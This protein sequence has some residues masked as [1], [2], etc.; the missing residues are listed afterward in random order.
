MN[1]KVYPDWVQ[2]HK[3]RGTTIKKV[4]GN[5]YLYGS[6]GKRVRVFQG[7]PADVPGQMEGSTG[8]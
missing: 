7:G 4:G 1:K 6:W 2:V 8:Q 3:V 5:Y